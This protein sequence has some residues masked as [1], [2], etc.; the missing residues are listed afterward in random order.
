MRSIAQL[1]LPLIVAL[2]ITDTNASL[3]RRGSSNPSQ[4]RTMSTGKAFKVLVTHP[5]VPQQGIDLLKQNCEVIQLQSVP[6]NRAEL[7][8]KIRGVDGVLWAGHEPLNAEALDA[9]GPQLKSI[10]AMSAGIDFVDVPELKRRKIPLGHTP[11]VLNTAVADL[12]VGLLIAAS[13]RFH[14]GRKKIDK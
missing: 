7:L 12:A 4:N 13:R 6:I 11:T 3:P 5:E 14:E 8:E 2:A 1:L 9:A 10:S